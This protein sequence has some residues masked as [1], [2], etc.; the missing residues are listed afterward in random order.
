MELSRNAKGTIAF[1]SVIMIAHVWTMLSAAY[2]PPWEE[3]APITPLMDNYVV[4]FLHHLYRP[5]LIGLS[6]LATFWIWDGRR[7]G[8]VIAAILAAVAAVF[9]VSIT[10]FNAL[11][12][13]LSGTFTALVAVAFPGVMALWF[14]MQGLREKGPGD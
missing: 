1:L 6:G 2:K 7:E 13:E 4:P 3:W 8:Y 11:A 5:L 14:S 9:G 12:G 10:V